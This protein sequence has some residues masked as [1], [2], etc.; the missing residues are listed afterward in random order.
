[1]F[2]EDYLA[3]DPKRPDSAI[4]MRYSVVP[5]Q[6]DALWGIDLDRRCPR[7]PCHVL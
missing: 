5:N 4:D 1:M 3:L 7:C 6:V 2:S